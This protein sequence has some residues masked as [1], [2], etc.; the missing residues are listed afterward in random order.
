MNRFELEKLL[1]QEGSDPSSLFI[2]KEIHPLDE[3]LLIYQNAS[4]SWT[5]DVQERGNRKTLESSGTE[6]ALCEAVYNRFSP[7]KIRGRS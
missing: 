7:K 4:G 5:A 1:I 3:G 2:S 6:T